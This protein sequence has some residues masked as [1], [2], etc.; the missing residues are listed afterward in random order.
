MIVAGRDVGRNESN[1]MKHNAKIMFVE[2]DEMHDDCV[3]FCGRPL[4]QLAHKLSKREIEKL[5]IA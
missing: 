5:E 1:E 4:L 2:R 3:W